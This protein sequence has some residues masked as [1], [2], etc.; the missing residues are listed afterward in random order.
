MTA[1][2]SR[3]SAEIAAPQRAFAGHPHGIGGHPQ[4]GQTERAQMRP[5]IGLAGE[6]QDLRAPQGIDDAAGQIGRAHIGRR[7][8]V[9]RVARRP[10]QEVA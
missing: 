2:A 10:A 6:F 3:F 9:D 5:P 7:R 1:P 4:P 8:R